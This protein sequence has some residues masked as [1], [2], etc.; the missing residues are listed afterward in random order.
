M[1][2]TTSLKSWAGHGLQVLAIICIMLIALPGS[3]DAQ[4]RMKKGEKAGSADY[5]VIFLEDGNKKK[6]RKGQLSSLKLGKNP[7][8]NPK[9]YWNCGGKTCTC[10]YRYVPAG[11]S[12]DVQIDDCL[13][14]VRAGMCRMMDP[15]TPDMTC[16][17]S[18]D[19]E[20]IA[21]RCVKAGVPS[22]GPESMPPLST[23]LGF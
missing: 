17:I 23:E 22:Q 2:Q 7:E 1:N 3:A 18:A 15:S 21:C 4:E 5:T 10:G 19:G 12:V 16:N 6:A 8:G 11:S 9:P 20:R 14:L 13:G